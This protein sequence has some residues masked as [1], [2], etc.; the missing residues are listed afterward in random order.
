M[1][2]P[3]AVVAACLVLGAAASASAQ[4]KVD[5]AAIVL[6]RVEGYQPAAPG[7]RPTGALT[8]NELAQFVPDAARRRSIST[9]ETYAR[10]FAAG[11]QRRA[12]V[13]GF[14][15]HSVPRARSFL[16]GAREH[17][18]DVGDIFPVG[19]VAH[20]FRVAVRPGRPPGPSV[21]QAFVQSGP[22][23]FVVAV[24]DTG[25]APVTEAQVT[26]VARAQAAAVPRELAAQE[27]ASTVADVAR[28]AGYALGFILP[29]AVV[30]GGVLY[31]RRP[32]ERRAGRQALRRSASASSR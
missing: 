17:A 12:V 16:G 30:A 7:I 11:G 23:V 18:V 24:W 21:Q 6:S 4:S 31:L 26:S 22:L 19:G 29:V 8:G 10:S 32:R 14:H 1:K 27:D 25:G 3:A 5:L 20:G 15:L 9:S 28:E 2:W 13:V